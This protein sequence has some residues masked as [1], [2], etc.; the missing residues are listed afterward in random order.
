MG[1]IGYD[2]GGVLSFCVKLLTTS[3]YANIMTFV[4]QSGTVQV[5]VP[6]SS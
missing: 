2:L 3:L 5:W 4:S 6:E 1:L